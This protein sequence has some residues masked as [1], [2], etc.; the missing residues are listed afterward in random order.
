MLMLDTSPVCAQIWA[1]DLSTIDCNEAAVRLYGFKD[2]QDY[3]DRF[4]SSCSPEYQPCG[5]RSD[6]KA[7]ALVNQAFE[8]GLVR[9][10]W[11]HKMPDSDVQI[12]AD[13]TLVRSVYKNQN[14]VIGYTVDMREQNALMEKLNAESHKFEETAHRYR[15]I[16]DAIPLM[17]SVTDNKKHMT[18]ANKSLCNFTGRT[19]EEMTGMPCH[20]MGTQICG[21]SACGVERAKRGLKQTFFDHAGFSF[22]ADVEMLRNLEGEI[23]GFIEVVQNITH[24]RDLMQQRTEAETASQT[25]SSFLA[26]MSHE[27]RTPMNAILG[28]TEILMENNTINED[29][30]EGLNKIYNSGNLLLGIINDILDFSKIEAGKM[31][32][33]PAPYNV[34]ELIG[35][36]AHLNALRIESKPIAFKVLPNVNI[37]AKLIG[38]ELRIKQILNNLLSNAFKYTETGTVTFTVDSEHTN[39]GT[40][41]VLGVR[42]T[43]IGMT[44]SQLQKIFEEYSRFGE[45]SNRGIEGTG[46][47][48]AITHRLVQLMNGSIHVESAYGNGTFFLI[49]LPKKTVDYGVLGPEMAENIRH[50]RMVQMG[51]KEKGQI[52]REPMPYGKVLVVDDIEPNL[53]VAEGLM[54][55]YGLHIEKVMSGEEAIMKVIAGNVYDIIFMDHMM[56]G[57]DGIETTLKL[58][59]YGYMEPVVALTAN[60][61]AGHADMFFQNGFN[62]FIS[63]PIDTRQLNHVLNK[64]VRDKQPPEVIEAA[65]KKIEALPPAVQEASPL[66]DAFRMIKGLDVAAA[67]AVLG[68]MYEVYEDTVRLSARLMPST[69]KKMDEYLKAGNLKAFAIEV[70]GLKGV[71]RSIG[72]AEIAAVAGR[73]E[74]SALNN[75]KEYCEETYPLLRETVIEFINNL[76]TALEKQPEIPKEEI[77]IAVL[78]ERIESART[79]ADGYDAIAALDIAKPLMKF[80]FGEEGEQLLE[81]AVFSLE[82]FDCHS[83]V[84]QMDKILD[85]YR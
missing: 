83:A 47:G 68:G 1:R 69:I 53:Y 18:F 34:A 21:T 74:I 62:E 40:Q 51:R 54:K 82:E 20:E 63:K 37:P 44:D 23:T 26:S 81:Q 19:L 78:L 60:A 59:E 35:D 57:M 52:L 50:F 38:D 46:L 31:D 71:T 55:P 75:G 49:K 64:L 56:P 7:V 36:S 39:E 17:V 72:A 42:D 27:I 85:I 70:H 61:L 80:S 5:R 10:D 11:M 32:I 41:L 15:S 25:K 9:F 67:L 3:I 58:R 30:K 6:E 66:I 28:V 22:Q 33:L 73:L 77:G 65:R 76:N 48:L 14:I 16:L 84:E 79:A 13:I 43:G 12:P 29:I 24:V 4:I 45:E 2:K 8:E